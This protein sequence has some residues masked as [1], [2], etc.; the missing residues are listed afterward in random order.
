M[1]FFIANGFLYAGRA[2]LWAGVNFKS[3]PS[4]RAY[5]GRIPVPGEDLLESALCCHFV[6]C[7]GLLFQVTTV[8]GE[9][10]DR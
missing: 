7:C 10:V 4:V 8:K 5:E 3:T 1:K 9:P 6:R 2:S